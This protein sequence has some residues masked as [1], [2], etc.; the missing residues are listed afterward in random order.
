MPPRYTPEA[1]TYHQLVI[2]CVDF[3]DRL[4]VLY[5]MQSDTWRAWRRTVE[6][7][8]PQEV[9]DAHERTYI[10]T[11]RRTTWINNKLWKA[12]KERMTRDLNSMKEL[13]EDAQ[14]LRA[15]QG[16]NGTGP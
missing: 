2:D 14:K 12:R 13:V 3:H 15:T 9:I 16:E 11:K 6:R 4:V 1:L 10:S 8:D 7:A 5:A